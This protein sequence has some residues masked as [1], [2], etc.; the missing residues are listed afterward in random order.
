[1]DLQ[2][3]KVMNSLKY[4]NCTKPQIERKR[5]VWKSQ[6]PRVAQRWSFHLRIQS[7]EREFSKVR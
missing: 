1:M 4:H 2:F 3:V 7:F 6:L 5:R